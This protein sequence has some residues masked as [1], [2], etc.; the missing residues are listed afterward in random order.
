MDDTTESSL[1]T[2]SFAGNIKSTARW[3][4]RNRWFFRLIGIG[5]FALILLKIDL[6]EAL[7]ILT[8]VN[9]LFLI[10]SLGLQAIALVVTTLRWQ[11]I[12]HRL[13]IHIPFLRSFIY[14]L[15][16]TAAALVTPGQL[17]EFI[18]VLYHRSHGFPVPESLLSVLI[19]RA[20]D[21]LMLLL[22]GFIALAVLFGIPP[23]L[24]VI[25][26]FGGGIVLVTGLLFARNK[27]DSTRW[28]SAVLARISPRAYKE[29]V[30]R[31]AQRLARRVS[32]FKLDFLIICG[33]LS[34]VNYTLLLLRNYSMV[35]ALH[36]DVP[37]WYFVMV[38]PLLRLVG[39]VPISISGIGTRDITA[40]YLLGQVGVPA[41][42][43]LILSA[44]GLLTLA[45]QALVGLFAWWRYPLQLSTGGAL[46][47]R[48]RCGEA[49]EGCE[50]KGARQEELV[51]QT[52]RRLQ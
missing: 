11:L 41:E 38:V 23:I 18:K 3:I 10:L 48:P 9:P 44:L 52:E 2:H 40:I 34:T 36:M 30:Q 14:Q 45:F 39:L 32:E 12:M 13:E 20:Y 8:T 16:G 46:E 50:G 26:A 27:E 22:F 17:G 19:D 25:I 33:L 47:Q 28:L 1:M 31:N 15:I 42:S 7:R 29:A 5:V 24:T 51:E 6:G 4:L 21:L 43:S 37:F 35:L 49:S